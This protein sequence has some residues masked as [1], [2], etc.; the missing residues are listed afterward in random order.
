MTA[1]HCVLTDAYFDCD[2]PHIGTRFAP[3]RRDG[4]SLNNIIGV[5]Y[6]EING[7]YVVC[8]GIVVG[9]DVG[10]LTF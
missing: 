1:N 3:D 7:G 10:D 8:I 2:V 6:L 4:N 9:M 5:Q